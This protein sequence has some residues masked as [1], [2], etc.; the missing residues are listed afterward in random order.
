MTKG[1][2]LGERKQP[3]NGDLLLKETEYGINP[4]DGQWYARPPGCQTGGLKRHTVTEHED[5]TITVK[6]SIL[7]EYA[8]KTSN[9]SWHGY[10]ENGSWREC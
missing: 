3:E 2:I 8:T 1:M 7:V 6:P 10:L 9:V 5:G 4:K